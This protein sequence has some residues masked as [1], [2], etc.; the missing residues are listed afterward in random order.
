MHLCIR[1]YIFRTRQIKLCTYIYIY[2]CMPYVG[3]YAC[4]SACMFVV[5]VFVCICV[6][7]CVCVSE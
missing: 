3:V 4:M 7:V 6:C 2:I 1:E 5:L